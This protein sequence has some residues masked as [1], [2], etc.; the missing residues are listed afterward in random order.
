MS[1]V[2]LLYPP[3]INPVSHINIK[4]FDRI[5]GCYPPLGLLYIATYLKKFSEYEVEILDCFAEKIN[6][7]EIKDKIREIQPDIIG[8]SAMTHF[9]V[10]VIELAKISKEL[11]PNIKVIV[12]G[13][14][15]TIYPVTTVKNEYIDYA[16]S[17]EAEICF[18][19]LIDAI[20]DNRSEED[21]FQ[22]PGVAN[23]LHVK[24]QKTDEDI[25][26]QR[27]NNLNEI[28][29]PD[30][31][32][33]D[34]GKYFSVLFAKKGTFTILM[35]SR[36]CPFNCIFCDRLGKNFRPVEAKNVIQ[37]IKACINLGIGKFFIHDDTFT[38]DKER[39][40]Q[41]C[42]TIIK[43][44]LE[45]EWEARSRVDCV[46][47]GLLKIMKEAGLGRISFGVE[48]GNERILANLRKRITLDRVKEVF[49]W[50]REL[51]IRTLADFMIGSPGETGKEINDTLNFIKQI[52]PNYVQFCITCPYP[53]TPLYRKLLE[54]GKIKSDVWLEFS[55]NP[56]IN[57]VPPIASE[58]FSREELERIVARAYR[59]VYFSLPFIAREMKKIRSP[60]ML[61]ARLKSAFYLGIFQR[62]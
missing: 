12:G 50:C 38:V 25:E 28:P 29:F 20:I 44:G 53:A 52:M 47:Y 21:I 55:K 8:I 34:N 32:L 22:I 6:F 3:I 37:E 49:K 31:N 57:F 4:A 46:D 18:K 10:D 14:H 45:I 43:D 40:R 62:V 1:K 39:V 23:K 42:E 19:N 15:A 56:H 27:N 13:P 61:F 24:Q 54:E 59:R 36:G 16:V 11:F 51:R 17:G 48:S 7:A 9:L 35:T 30:R 5:I 41:I 26:Q 2:L 33:I 60:E 58:Y